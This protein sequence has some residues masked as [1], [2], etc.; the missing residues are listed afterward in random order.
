M[1]KN[2]QTPP[3]QVL[4]DGFDI[5][6]TA[7]VWVLDEQAQAEHE[8]CATTVQPLSKTILG[9]TMAAASQTALAFASALLSQFTKPQGI[10]LKR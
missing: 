9:Q 5:M 7:C 4:I 2:I 3:N 10:L 8:P 6:N 1:A